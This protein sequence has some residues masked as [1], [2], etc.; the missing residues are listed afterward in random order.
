MFRK[1]NIIMLLLILISGVALVT[2]EVSAEERLLQETIKIEELYDEISTEISGETKVALINQIVDTCESL[3]KE[4]PDYP[5][6]YWLAAYNYSNIV[7]LDYFTEEDYLTELVE[8]GKKYAVE[9]IKLAPDESRSYFL[10]ATLTAQHAQNQGL[11]ARLLSVSE[12]KEKLEKAIELDPFFAPAYDLM[13][14]L[15]LEAPAWPLSIGDASK[16]LGYRKKSIELFSKLESDFAFFPGSE[17]SLFVYKWRLYENY[18]KLDREEKARETLE[19]LV[20]LSSE[21]EVPNE[22][23]KELINIAEEKLA[24]FN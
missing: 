10:T 7:F 22:K 12:I 11:F 9:S 6:T 4:Y 24:S 20:D 23:V 14:Q 1:V 5:E 21:V 2:V 15:Y 16:A 18:L 8:K 17:P 19:K 3:I 13:A